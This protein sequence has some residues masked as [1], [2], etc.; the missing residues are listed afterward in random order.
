[1]LADACASEPTYEVGLPFYFAFTIF[2]TFDGISAANSQPP[3]RTAAA[4]RVGGNRPPPPTRVL[5][6]YGGSWIT[7]AWSTSVADPQS[8]HVPR[9]AR[10]RAP[11]CAAS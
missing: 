6:G 9:T 7:Q 4:I 8:G 11:T 1:M 5:P 2:I 3:Q 10:R